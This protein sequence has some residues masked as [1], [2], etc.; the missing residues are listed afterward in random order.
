MTEDR[1]IVTRAA[2]LIDEIE[3]LARHRQFAADSTAVATRADQ[4]ERLAAALRAR[5]DQLSLFRDRGIFP[6][7]NPMSA[8]GLLD[9][10]KSHRTAFEQDHSSIADDPMDSKFKWRY[11]ERLAHLC[12]SVDQA[13]AETW[14]RYVASIAPDSNDEFLAV[15]ERLPHFAADAQE[16]AALRNNLR[17]TG[18]PQTAP[19]FERAQA[20]ATAL[21]SHYEKLKGI[22]KDVRAFLADA[23]TEGASIDT[24]TP[25]IRAWLKETGFLGSLRYVLKRGA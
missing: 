23:T 7:I 16:I 8:R 4:L 24:L 14:D 10:T 17:A 18:P 22:P 20:A 13:L 1:G 11:Q 21:N 5:T 9:L 15:L 6:N 3:N 12:Q 2:R 19:D 25:D